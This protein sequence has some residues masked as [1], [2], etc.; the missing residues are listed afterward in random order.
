MIKKP[1]L[2]IFFSFISV[3]VYATHNR[4]GEITFNQLSALSFKVNIVTYTKTSS[5][6]DRP[7]LEIRW[8]DGTSD[9]LARISKVSVGTDISRNLYEGIHTYPGPNIYKIN[10]EDP[11]R[12]GGVANIPGSVNV[13]FYIETQ[14]IISPQLNYN[15][16]P[17]LLEPPIDDGCV[18]KLFLHNPN[19]FDP[20]GDSL[21][22]ELIK[23][24]GLNGLDIPGYFFPPASNSF[25]IDAVTG[26]LIWDS[27]QTQGEY[28]VA[29]IIREWRN[30]TN[31]GYVE[32]DMQITI[33]ACNNVA[34]SITPAPDL[35]VEAGTFINFIVSAFDPDTNV[36]T[37]SATG[38]P[39]DANLVAPPVASFPTLSATGSVTGNFTWQTACMHVRKAPYQVLFKATDNNTQVNLIDFE[40]CNITVVAPAPQN[41][42]AQPNADSILVNWDAETCANAIGYKLYRRNGFYGYNHGPCETGVPAYTGYKLIAQLQGINSTSFFDNNNGAGLTPG[43][44]YCYIVVAYFA[45]SAQSYASLEACTVLKR[46]RPVITNV[47]INTTNV[48]TG[49]IYI[50]WSSPKEIDTLQTPGPY[51][52]K[53]YRSPDFSGNSFSYVTSFFNLNDTTMID[54]FLNTRDNP[55]SY[56]IEFWNNTP[57]NTF[58]VGKSAT[59][60]S[61][62]LSTSPTD[63]RVNLSWEEHVPWINNKYVVYRYDIPSAQFIVL[64]TVSSSSF[65]DSGLAN[66]STFCYKIESIGGYTAGGTIN[67]ILNFSQ[68]KCDTPID[69]VKPC[70]PPAFSVKADCISNKL[71]LQW[72]NPND[73]C[74]DDVLRYRIYVT[75]KKTDEPFFLLEVSSANIT[76]L[77]I[78]TMFFVSGCYYITAVDSAG[79][80]SDY[81]PAACAD[82]CPYYTIPNVFTP[83]GDFKNDFLIPFPYRFVESVDLTIY[84]RWGQQVFH[85]NDIDINWK[86]TLDNGSKKCSAGTYYYVCTVKEIFLDGS[87]LRTFHGTVEIIK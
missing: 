77:S 42:T 63:N 67:P 19:A 35:C 78:D 55:W 22:Y 47:S 43:N 32:R 85:T 44:D 59:A 76:S 38:A 66:D 68:E 84:N 6:A 50:A 60:S 87:V 10:F 65:T 4:A 45:D 74:S 86:G 41:L 26:D 1:L 14:L 39:L 20:D 61:V 11:N 82:Y 64:D 83:N 34:P 37:L 18:N 70:A 54:S 75:R 27:P 21:S 56:K 72:S 48:S 58:M 30:G 3:I 62:F 51:E 17:L 69:N 9:S 13:P 16:S 5:P 71:E 23:C 12:N 25:S 52:Y 79:N 36:V 29:F 28:N 81:S 57:G 7:Y 15:N 31:I 2:F 8:G 80:E 40:R 46:D 49:T 33:A 24:K 53:V 73:S